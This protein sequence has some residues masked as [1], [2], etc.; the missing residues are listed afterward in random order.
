MIRPFISSF[1]S[2]TA[3]TVA[4]TLCSA[5]ILWIA[6]A[7]IFFASRSAFRLAV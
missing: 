7:M 6:S 5:A 1:G 4:S 3:E 2:D